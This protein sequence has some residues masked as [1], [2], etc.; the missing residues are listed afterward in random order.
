MGNRLLSALPPADFDLLADELETVVLEQDAALT[1][2][3]DPAEH[4]LF[5]H[6]GAISLMIDMRDGETVAT[7]LVGREGAVGSLAVLGPLPSAITAIVRAP[8]TASRIP[9]ARFHAAFGRS[10]A[11]RN[12]VQLHIRAMLAQLQLGAA[13]N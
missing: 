6:G 10:P 3:G 4:M 12:V 1:R 9:A 7:A 2:A 8:G 13:C 11:I 5:P